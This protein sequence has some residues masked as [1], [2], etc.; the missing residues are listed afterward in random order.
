MGKFEGEKTVVHAVPKVCTSVRLASANIR[1][2]LTV[3]NVSTEYG[4]RIPSEN[5]VLMSHSQETN[6]LYRQEKTATS[7]WLIWL[8]I[9]GA[10]WSWCLLP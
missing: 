8:P 9:A 10:Q 5:N 4:V 7:L 1:L 3:I 6:L 2:Q